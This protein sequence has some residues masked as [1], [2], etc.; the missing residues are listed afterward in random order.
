MFSTASALSRAQ[1]PSPLP[2]RKVEAALVYPRGGNP[3]SADGCVLAREEE[4]NLWA[5]TSIFSEFY[6]KFGVIWWSFSG[7]KKIPVG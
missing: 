1:L 2:V 3:R 7:Q 6:A 4:E 5:K